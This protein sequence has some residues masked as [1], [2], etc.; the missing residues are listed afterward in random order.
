MS[1][2]E[3]PSAPEVRPA[4]QAAKPPNASFGIW[5]FR[6][7]ILVV[8][9]S[10]LAAIWWSFAMVMSPRL[11]E[12]RELSSRVSRLSGEVDDL[13]RQWTKAGAGELS[14]QFSRVDSKLFEGQTEFEAWL[15]DFKRQAAP[16]ALEVRASLGQP[17]QRTAG[18]RTMTLI[19]ATLTVEVQPARPE[20]KPPSPYARLL[21][22]GQRLASEPKRADLQ[23]LTIEAG[24]NSVSRAV[25]VLNYWMRKEATP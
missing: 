5:L 21:L 25:L 13:D 16:L 20:T 12:S 8:V 3:T 7:V 11:K 4:A 23:E 17:S 1:N 9:L 22:L 24:T 19:P 18:D 2:G 15:A 14:N 10:S 6:A